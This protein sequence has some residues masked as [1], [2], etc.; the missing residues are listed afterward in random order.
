MAVYTEEKGGSP[1]DAGGF[2]LGSPMPD[3]GPL[4]YLAVLA[5][6]LSPLIL[7]GLVA[8]LW[9]RAPGARRGVGL[10]LVMALGLVAVLALLP[11]KADRYVLPAIPFLA[12]V[13]AVGLATL[14][15]R[16]PRR[17]AIALVGTVVVAHA[18]MLLLVWPYPLA[19]YDP[20]LGGG[21]AAAQMISVGWGEGL[22]QVAEAVNRLPGADQLTVA[23]PYPEALQAQ[24]AGRAVDLDEYDVADYAVSYIAAGQRRLANPEL[25]AAIAGRAPIARVTIAGIPY[26]EVY[27]LDRPAFGDEAGPGTLRV[28]QVAISPSLTTR[29][30]NVTVQLAWDGLPPGGAASPESLEAELTLVDGDDG[31]PASTLITPVVPDGQPRAWTLKAP[32]RRDRF[33]LAV[34]VRNTSEGRWLPVTT[35]PIGPWH[36]PDR[37]VFPPV[38]V[39]VQ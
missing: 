4:Y 39:R 14:A 34:R 11:K 24:L 20:L 27:P 33:V 3:P 5:L 35:W 9:V 32:N 23:S 22:D 16:W 8:W 37:I 2:F 13:A 7:A 21:R 6:R 10:M 1:M 38:G 31:T 29:G 12:V 26:A 17:G 18:A 36:D 28:S 30:A 15:R 19:F 25:D